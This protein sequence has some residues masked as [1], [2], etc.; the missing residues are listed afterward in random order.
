MAAFLLTP[1][2]RQLREPGARRL[3][4]ARHC[5]GITAGEIARGIEI[6]A[7]TVRAEA[8]TQQGGTGQ[9]DTPPIRSRSTRHG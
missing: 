3:A 8:A 9:S 5:P 4:C 2:G 6:A 7:E 1:R